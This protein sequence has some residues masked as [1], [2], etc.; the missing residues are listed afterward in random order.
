LN[1]WLYIRLLV[2]LSR[3]V[4]KK[5]APAVSTVFEFEKSTRDHD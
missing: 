2:V 4:G 5:I 1:V 3:R